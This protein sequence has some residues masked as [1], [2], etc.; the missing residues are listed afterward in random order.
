MTNQPTNTDAV[1]GGNNQ[2]T[3]AV[4]GGIEGAKR[5]FHQAKEFRQRYAAWLEIAKYDP[6]EAERLSNQ[7]I[8][9]NIKINEADV[10]KINHA[11]MSVQQAT[12]NMA[13]VIAPAFKIAVDVY[14]Q[15]A[16]TQTSGINQNQYQV[17][18]DL[19]KFTF[20][21]PQPPLEEVTQGLRALI[22]QSATLEELSEAIRLF[23][24]QTE[25]EREK[26]E[27]REKKHLAKFN[28]CSYLSGLEQ[29]IKK[30]RKWKY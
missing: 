30:K 11:I 20:T 17:E 14:Q 25:A 15:L 8:R 16:Q 10:Q 6:T 23:N 28:Q 26:D 2:T 21:S 7:L 29:V 19:E 18:V 22:G 12:V 24:A 4:I 13:S 9:L 3:A 27:E 1:L 5:R